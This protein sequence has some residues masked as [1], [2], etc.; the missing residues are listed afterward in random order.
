MTNPSESPLVLPDRPDLR[1]LKNQAK[2]LVRTGRAESF[3]KAQ[4]RVARQY[5][6]S[7]WPK[8][9][10]YVESVHEAW[11]LKAA[12]DDEDF[13]RAR[14][15]MTGNPALH[16]APIGY[17]KNGP[18]TWLAECRIPGG[19]PSAARLEMARWMITHGSDVHQGGDGPLMRATLND[20]R[21][22]MAELLLAHGADVNAMWAGRYPIIC[23]PCEC[24]APKALRW[25]LAHGADPHRQSIDYGTPL[26][27]VIG[28]Y[29]RHVK[30]RQECLEVLGELGL[31]LPDTPVMAMHRGRS[32]LL[33]QHLRRDPSLLERRFSEAEIYPPELGLNPGD[34]LHVTPVAGAALLHI[35]V[36]YDDVD[37]ARWLLER[38]T[39]ANVRAAV[40]HQGFG[41]HTPLFHAV[42]TLGS[43]DDL[44]AR[45]LLD[46]G[47]DPNARATLRKQLRG[48][49]D[50]EKERV[51]E[52]H[53]VTP[54][55]YARQFQE[56]GMVSEP[57]L[58]LLAGYGGVE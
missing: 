46:H 2:D 20:T 41:G 49:G 8:L 6:F 12:I 52:F 11:Q 32:D 1:H 38:G 30:R 17:G 7:S 14:D 26:A 25:L 44:K 56:P 58:T 29:S 13:E 43:R 45:L 27:M 10:A 31:K 57:A 37:T 5:G 34:G 55:G 22:P 47:A 24:L 9:K 36:E 23:G 35:A 51:V 40:D 4:H 18:L 19:A 21:I 54:T 39:D 16:R 15:L 3:S 28:T 33:E 50:L 53:N 42:V 48:T